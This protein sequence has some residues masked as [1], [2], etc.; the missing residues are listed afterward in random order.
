MK[1]SVIIPCH[2][3]EKT[4]KNTIKAIPASKNILE[5]IVVDN[6]SNDKTAKIAKSCGAKVFFEAQQGYGYAIKRGLKE[7]KG[8]IIAVLDGDGQY[9]A[10][11]IIEITDFL[12]KNNLDF[13]SG[14]RFPLENTKALP[15][16]RKIGNYILTLFANA[17]FGTNLKDSQSGMWVFKRHLLKKI[18][19]ISN[20]MPISEE[21]KL[22]TILQPYL[23]F[24]EYQIPYHPRQGDSK[25]LP[26]KHGLKNL[27]FL[28]KLA[29]SN[30]TSRQFLLKRSLPL[31]ALLIIITA[32]L[33]FS[34]KYISNPFISV[35]ADTNGDNGLAAWNLQKY[36]YLKMKFGNY[37]QWIDN[38]TDEKI[39]FYTNHPS[40]FLLPTSFLYKF[41]GKSEATT[42][43]GPLIMLLLS[44]IIFFF[45]LKKLFRNFLLSFLATL[46]FAILPGTIYYGQTFELAVFSLPSALFSFSLFIFYLYN[47][48]VIYLILFYL[49]IIFGGLMGWFYYFMPLAIIILLILFPPPQLSKLE[50][51][52][53][54]IFTAILM[55]LVFILNLV[56]FYI[57]NGPS[58]FDTL[59]NAFLIRTGRSAFGP[60]LTRIYWLLKLH[61]TWLFL[62]ISACGLLIYLQKL[63][64][65][66]SLRLILPLI[67]MPLLN[68]IVFYQWSTHPFGVIY[69][70]PIIGVT[71]AIC[72]STTY[73]FLINKTKSVFFK[74]ILSVVGLIIL[75]YGLTLTSKKLDFF[76]NKL[77]ILGHQDIN[78]L[79]ELKPQI[80]SGE[81]C[82]SR[83]N[84]G[85]GFTGITQ[86]YIEKKTTMSPQCLD[87]PKTKFALVFSWQLG[88]FYINEIDLFAKNNFKLNRCAYFW[89]LMTKN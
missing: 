81:L 22:K 34:L 64:N 25:L 12:V 9:P 79:K 80:Q 33:S 29:I 72:L 36:G 67:L 75:G 11:K 89:C 24:R 51:I 26:I 2:N 40:F 42:R 70:L 27:F 35:T 32:N 23:R 30:P 19:L 31:I 82:L 85:L 46:I 14:C 43:L 60:W 10:E 41:F 58:V 66:A 17:L 21:I 69:L 1:I 77:L 71:G 63:K 38:L 68:F 78:L 88:Q 49:S 52:K 20:D 8:E 45:A 83:N 4:I 57:L 16:T 15:P 28:I 50:R 56:H 87:S 6:N 5:I 47:R 55:S 53:I 39:T 62:T 86:W 84:F 18:K 54:A 37:P 76:Y 7:A 73:N 61:A 59:K 74:P 3:E 48:K 65:N 44:V 13:V